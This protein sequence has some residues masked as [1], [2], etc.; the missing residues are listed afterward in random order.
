MICIIFSVILFMSWMAGY[1]RENRWP[2]GVLKRI[3]WVLHEKFYLLENN[4]V[5]AA[6]CIKYGQS[7]S[8]SAKTVQKCS[9]FLNC[10]VLRN[11]KKFQA[12]HVINPVHA[13]KKDK[14]NISMFILTWFTDRSK[15]IDI[16]HTVQSLQV[17]F[18]SVAPISF[19]VST[20][21]WLFENT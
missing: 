3:A 13:R 19:P 8:K 4:H 18:R 10:V 21:R 17:L 12:T 14:I 16:L 5:T 1:G 6:V 11:K 9:N 20:F 7:I 15:L 2:V